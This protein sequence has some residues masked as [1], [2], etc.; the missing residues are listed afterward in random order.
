MLQAKAAGFYLGPQGLSIVEFNKGKIKNYLF[1]PYPQNIPS[2]SGVLMPRDS[3]FKVFLDNEVEILAFLQKSIRDSRIDFEKDKIALAVPTTD[4]I[5]RFFEIP[6]IP[7]KDIAATVNFEIKKYIPF[8]T[9]DI[10]YDYQ[11]RLEEKVIE[12]LFA[13]IKNDDLAK[14]SS[15]ISQSKINISAVEPSLF[16]LLRLLKIKKVVTVK[17]AAVVLEL[18]KQ[19]GSIS[20]I[21]NGLPCFSRDIKIASSGESGEAEES[22]AHFRIIN[23]VRVSI[24]Y[25]R[26]Q[27]LKKAIEKIIVIS[28]S[29][30]KELLSVFNKELSLPVIYKSSNDLIGVKDEHSLDLA[31]AFGASMR[32]VKSSAL[33]V[34]LA[35]KEQPAAVVSSQKIVNDLMGELSDIPKATLFKVFGLIV[36]TIIGV[37]AYCQFRLKPYQEELMVVS[38]QA[39][40][41]LVQELSGMNV[42]ALKDHKQKLQNK[43]KTY[44]KVFNKGFSISEKIKI[45]AQLLPEGMWLE[46]ITFEKERGSF[47]FK[48]L[49]YKENESEAQAVP[50]ELISRL[51]KSNLFSA[52]ISS[53]ET[54]GFRSDTVNNYK[55]TRFEVQIKL[56]L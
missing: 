24:D 51:K 14:Y 8:K 39:N 38:K 21:V 36:V 20:I 22:S 46:A 7:K 37:F 55:V 19:D 25:F 31:K 16:S 32:V 48:G 28:S 10:T 3:I 23:E 13:G 6:P 33:T 9:E 4:L 42:A 29:E 40:E 41:A 17:D 34:N 49:V 15:L 50:Y 11:T 27:F 2:P 47:Y 56:S 12:V 54:K 26:R 52:K 30:S 1:T 45:L 35:K 18:G 43:I 44:E 5:V 53:I